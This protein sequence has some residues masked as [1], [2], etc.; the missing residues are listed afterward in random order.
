MQKPMPEP[1]R[2]QAPRQ[3]GDDPGRSLGLEL[4]QR[5]SPRQLPDRAKAIAVMRRAHELIRYCEP[6]CENEAR[7]C[8]VMDVAARDVGLGP[9]EYR[10]IVRGDVE[11]KELERRALDGIRASFPR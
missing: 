4:L 1:Q 10:A 3:A 11:L 8:D 9:E 2:A 5:A 6:E 7:L